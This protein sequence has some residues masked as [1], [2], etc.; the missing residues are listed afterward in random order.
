MPRISELDPL[1]RPVLASDYLLIEVADKCFRAP[2]TSFTGPT[3]PAGNTGPAGQAGPAGPAGPTGPT[4]PA[5]TPSTVPGPSGPQG[6]TGPA[7]PTG[8][9]GPASTI[10]GPAGPIGP[11]G[12]TGPAG[13]IAA[14]TT[15]TFTTATLAGNAEASGTVDLAPCFELLAI[16]AS[17]PC[18]I[19]L[20]STAAARAADQA[21]AIGTEATPGLGVV[22]EVVTT[23]AAVQHLDPHAHGASMETTPSSAI[24]YRI[25]NTSGAPAT[26]TLTLTFIPR[27]G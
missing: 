1:D 13:P 12:P 7:G 26:L 22:A 23:A 16:E 20:Y 18:R 3:G 15:A 17:G 19:R 24:P 8:P 27:E 9:T 21:R 14:R 5:G 4:G 2:G 25:Q 10:P 6:P 11:T